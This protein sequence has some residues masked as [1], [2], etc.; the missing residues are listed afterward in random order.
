M[1]LPAG[2]GLSRQHRQHQDPTATPAPGCASAAP[3]GGPCTSCTPATG[4][5]ITV[6]PNPIN[7]T[8]WAPCDQAKAQSRAPLG[9]PAV[10]PL[11]LFG[12]I[13]WGTD[14]RKG[15]DLLLEALQGLR[16]QVDG[17]PLEQL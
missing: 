4:W 12:A 11:V 10:R 15:A 14:P 7:L 5:P 9:L 6:I 3:G 8:V 1:L 13:G 17:T 16:R 2:E